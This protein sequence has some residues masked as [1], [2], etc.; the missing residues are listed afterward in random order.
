MSKALLKLFL[1]LILMSPTIEAVARE[2]SFPLD[3][4]KHSEAELEWWDFFGHLVDSENHI[5]GFSLNFMRVRVNPQRPPSLWRTE[6][7]YI[8]HF[9]ITDGA[10][11]QFYFQEKENRT[12]FNLAGASTGQLWI[13]NRNWKAF[14]NA[15]NSIVLQAETKNASLNIRLSP[16]KSPILFGQNGFFDTQNLYYYS[17]PNLQ[18]E[19]ELRLGEHNHQIVTIKGGM[20]HAFQNNKNSDIVWDKFV[21]Q[22]NNG[23]DIFLY[24]LA[25]KKS[26]FISPE[27][28]CIINHANEK[29]VLLSLADFRF[30]KLNS[31]ES[32]SSK[33][34]YPSGWTLTI[35]SA[36]YRLEIVPVLSDQEIVALDS[37]Y[38]GGQSLIVGE[39]DGDLITGYAY[40]E[41][42]KKIT[43]D[44]IL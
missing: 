18:G 23:D 34:T 43:R 4:G 36:H 24:I 7:I 8:S 13:W 17:F 28:F 31:W 16:I 42:S 22:L 41:L 6:D 1:V 20:D 12:S 2:F 40:V 26:G 9:T 39:K 27:S 35:P 3:H 38:W 10:D 21:I 14:M 30:T 19:G 11:K 5:F 25:S 44:Y 33:I 29:A 15:T 32:D 37:T